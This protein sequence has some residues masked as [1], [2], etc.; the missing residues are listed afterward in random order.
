MAGGGVSPSR[1]STEG[2]EDNEEPALAG[3]VLFVTFCRNAGI[4]FSCTL[5]ERQSS[6]TAALSSLSIR[7]GQAGRRFVWSDLFGKITV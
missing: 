5:V 6:P 7:S 2:N 4:V 1:I 3:F